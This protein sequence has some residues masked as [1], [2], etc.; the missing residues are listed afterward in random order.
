MYDQLPAAQ[1]LSA[2]MRARCMIGFGAM[3]NEPAIAAAPRCR[4]YFG[5]EPTR[6]FGVPGR[7]AASFPA[8]CYVRAIISPFTHALIS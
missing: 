8:P 6:F 1:M 5:V 4:R 7:R 3:P 2:M